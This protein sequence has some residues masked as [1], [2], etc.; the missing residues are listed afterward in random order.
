MS[1]DSQTG[2]G[3]MDRRMGECC[4]L[5]QFPTEKTI[6]VDQKDARTSHEN[7]SAGALSEFQWRESYSSLERMHVHQRTPLWLANIVATV[8]FL[9]FSVTCAI[10]V[11]QCALPTSPPPPPPIWLEASSSQSY[12]Q[13][14][15]MILRP[16][17]FKR[18]LL[19]PSPAP[20]L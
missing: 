2:P 20:P 6:K 13:Y 14:F 1:Q 11:V 16:R 12:P 9:E 5:L 8:V 17:A 4:I 3:G 15:V 7:Y 18:F 19:P 10:G